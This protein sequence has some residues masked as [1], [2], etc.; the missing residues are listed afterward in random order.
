M[1]SEMVVWEFTKLNENKKEYDNNAIRPD[2]HDRLHGSDL[3]LI[4]ADSI[5]NQ[6]GRPPSSH[7][8]NL[9]GSSVPASSNDS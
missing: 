3:Y 9:P 8:S 5:M 6:Q 2:D 1:D 4:R 7:A